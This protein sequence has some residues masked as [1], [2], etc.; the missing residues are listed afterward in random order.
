MKALGIAGSPRRGRNTETLP[1]RFLTGAEGAGADA[2]KI[3][4]VR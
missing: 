4:V 2:E 3:V 1:D